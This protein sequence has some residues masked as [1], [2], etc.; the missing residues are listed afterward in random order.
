MDIDYMTT[1]PIPRYGDL[2]PNSF[3]SSSKSNGMDPLGILGVVLNPIGSLID[4]IF[5]SKAQSNANKANMQLAQ[6][7]WQ[8]QIDMWNRN[9][10]YNTP[11]NQ[12]ARL[13]DAGLNP[14]L[15]YGHGSVAN[16]SGSVP[17]PQLPTMG[18]YT[19]INVGRSAAESVSQYLQLKQMQANIRKT[20]VE[21][22]HTAQDTNNLEVNNTLLMQQRDY[23]KLLY[24]AQQLKNSKTRAEANVWSKMLDS[25]IAEHNSN[26]ARN[27]SQSSESDSR[28]NSNEFHL[29]SDK[30][31]LDKERGSKL[32]LTEA[33]IDN[34]NITTDLSLA[35][36]QDVMADIGIKQETRAKVYL[37]GEQILQSLSLGEYDFAIKQ[38][39]ILEKF[40]TLKMGKGN[41]VQAI[42]RALQAG[43]DE[44]AE[45]TGQAPL[46][47]NRVYQGRGQK[48]LRPKFK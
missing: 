4:G 11:K 37:E 35:R 5:N 33:Q 41:N 26:V 3:Y 22:A 14:N 17:T 32:L 29:A 24:I 23:N 30:K 44:I 34:V 8:Q 16:T 21:T 19:G 47:Y 36:I 10:S 28:R 39:D 9:N 27:Y 1:A 46:I 15:V 6:Y 40:L 13:K 43:M 20:E 7:N 18:A 12:M 48:H 2:L 25:Q 31:W 45:H 42:L 38:Y